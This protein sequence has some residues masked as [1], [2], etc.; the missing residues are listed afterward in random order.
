[1][2]WN[3]RRRRRRRRR[4]RGLIGALAAVLLL[5]QAAGCSSCVDDAKKEE[6]APSGTQLAP[7]QGAKITDKRPHALPAWEDAG[8]DGSP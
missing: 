6:P 8:A 4:G 3:G 7:R 2:R 1:M 5:A